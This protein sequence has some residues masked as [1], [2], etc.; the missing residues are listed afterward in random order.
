MSLFGHGFVHFEQHKKSLSYFIGFFACIKLNLLFSLLLFSM[1]SKKTKCKACIYLLL[2]LRANPRPNLHTF[3]QFP[4]PTYFSEKKITKKA[5]TEEIKGKTLMYVQCRSSRFA[6]DR[7]H[8]YQQCFN[9]KWNF[10]INTFPMNATR[11]AI[12]WSNE[13]RSQW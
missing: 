9:R 5:E 3:L 2:C 13:N 1:N 4:L 10:S 6:W 7:Q 12:N 11:I 8:Q